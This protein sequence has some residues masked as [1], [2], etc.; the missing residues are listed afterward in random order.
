[1]KIIRK[2][3]QT[4]NQKMFMSLFKHLKK[5]GE[6]TFKG[7]KTDEWNKEVNQISENRL[8]TAEQSPSWNDSG[9]EKLSELSKN[10]ISKPQLQWVMQEREEEFDG[11]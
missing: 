8:S 4:M 10:P 1:M 3:F 5:I 9:N 2:K 11:S 7:T 6:T